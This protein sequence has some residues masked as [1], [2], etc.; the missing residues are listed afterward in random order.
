MLLLRYGSRKCSEIF[1]NVHPSQPSLTEPVA[2]RV[3]AEV[4]Q[5]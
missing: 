4:E 3:C 1:E 5:S 2:G